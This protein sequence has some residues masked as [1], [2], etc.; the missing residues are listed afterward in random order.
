MKLSLS[1]KTKDV[2]TYLSQW[3]GVVILFLFIPRVV[4]L[5]FWKITFYIFLGIAIILLIWRGIRLFK[6]S[7]TKNENSTIPQNSN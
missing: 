6:N 3:I 7:G 5:R 1:M 4:E 2:I